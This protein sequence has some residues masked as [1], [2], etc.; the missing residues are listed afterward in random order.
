[1]CWNKQTG[2]CDSVCVYADILAYSRLCKASMRDDVESIT[3]LKTHITVPVFTS[4]R[5]GILNKWVTEYSLI[6]K[7]GKDSA[8]KHAGYGNERLLSLSHP[9][10]L[11]AHAHAHTP[12]HTYLLTPSY[13]VTQIIGPLLMSE[14]STTKPPL[15]WFLFQVKDGLGKVCGLRGPIKLFS[16]TRCL[17]LNLR[18][19]QQRS[20][21]MIM[22]EN[23]GSG[24]YRLNLS[25]SSVCSHAKSSVTLPVSCMGTSAVWSLVRVVLFYWTAGAKITRCDGALWLH[26]PTPD[27]SVTEHY[28]RQMKDRT[29]PR[30]R[31]EKLF[32][33]RT[34]ELV[35]TTFTHPDSR[36]ETT[37]AK[38]IRGI[39]Q[40]MDPGAVAAV[41]VGRINGNKYYGESK[42]R[43]GSLEFQEDFIPSYDS[44]QP[45]FPNRL[46]RLVGCCG[47]KSPHP[48]DVMLMLLKS[49]LVVITRRWTHGSGKILTNNDRDDEEEIREITCTS[50]SK[51]QKHIYSFLAV[52][53]F[54]FE[55]NISESRINK[56]F[57]ANYQ[58][59]SDN[60]IV[61][62]SGKLLGVTGSTVSGQRRIIRR[63]QTNRL[64]KT[65][66]CS[67]GKQ[68]S[69]SA[70]I[71]DTDTSLLSTTFLCK[72]TEYPV[73]DI[74][75]CGEKGKYKAMP[76]YETNL[77]KSYN[78]KM[79]ALSQVF[80]K[81][82]APRLGHGPMPHQQ[83]QQLFTDK[84]AARWTEEKGHI[85]WVDAHQEA[86]ARG[87]HSL[88]TTGFLFLRIF[89]DE[90]EGGIS[91]LC[92][93]IRS[94]PETTES[95]NVRGV[96]RAK[97]MILAALSIK[98]RTKGRQ[99]ELRDCEILLV[100]TVV[101]TSQRL[102]QLQ[103]WRETTAIA[104][105]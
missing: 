94:E 13:S 86:W 48:S 49:Q 42:E 39:A 26:V 71:I 38:L 8:M 27:A 62:A 46:F 87:K 43:P 75:Y 64:A 52:S 4:D 100:S 68:S 18:G 17:N 97:R 21:S 29:G 69:M 74:I 79:Y 19:S 53:S 60:I 88:E 40:D 50:I 2:E 31:I 33:H 11:A 57:R 66:Y 6:R 59:R 84:R 32:H 103:L 7:S 30:R 93:L 16:G 55:M 24:N 41:M 81:S 25:N 22:V 85:P 47:A 72:T 5:G 34:I 45:G 58:Q 3:A 104:N 9:I 89:T 54:H 44:L 51:T 73:E 67:T 70:C 96:N 15:F 80:S 20:E 35:S 83:Q 91:K 78:Y 10:P 105:S 99:L 63:F 28:Q 14:N 95:H 12:T 23:A 37:S 82:K 102:E 65:S 1:M 77:D 101:Q 56:L 76:R 90:S 92:G 36:W 98:L 61:L